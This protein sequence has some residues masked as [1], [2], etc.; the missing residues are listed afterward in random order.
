[1]RVFR[2]DEI[3]IKVS[4]S[5]CFIFFFVYLQVINEIVI[6]GMEV[7]VYKFLPNI[8]EKQYIAV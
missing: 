8:C 1:M 6:N 2:K 5:S 4:F 3:W 7:K